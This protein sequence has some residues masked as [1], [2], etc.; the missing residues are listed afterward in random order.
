MICSICLSPNARR[1]KEVIVNQFDV[2]SD[3]DG[4]ITEVDTTDFLLGQL[5]HPRWRE[6]EA[7]WEA[8]LIGSRECMAA[9]VGLIRGGW[10]AVNSA[11]ADVKLIAHF[12][13]LLRG[14]EKSAYLCEL[15]ATAWT[16]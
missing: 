1:L 15:S 2:Y 10:K 5:A 9:Q 3:F 8:G 16:G 4:T 7:Q 13:S 11:L 6:I 14:A 12:A